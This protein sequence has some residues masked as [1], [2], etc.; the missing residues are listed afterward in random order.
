M[1]DANGD[2]RVDLSDPIVVLRYMTEGGEEPVCLEATDLIPDGKWEADDG[3]TLLAHVTEGAFVIPGAKRSRCASDTPHAFPACEDLGVSFTPSG[4]D[5]HVLVGLAGTATAVEAWHLNLS[6]SDC[7]ITAVTPAGT[8]SA[9]QHE[10]SQGLRDVGYNLSY[11]TGGNALSSVVLDFQEATALSL[12]PR[13]GTAVLDITLDGCKCSL[14]ADTPVEGA[15]LLLP[16]HLV[17]D[18]ASFPVTGSAT[19]NSCNG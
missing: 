13:V 15:G 1:G 17:I 9:S 8:A 12:D 14:S 5:N 10:D 19:V 16:S 4:Q 11:V 7:T 18:G 2:G 6:S 3:F